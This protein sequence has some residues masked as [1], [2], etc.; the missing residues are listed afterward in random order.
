MIAIEINNVKSFMNKLLKDN[1]FDE[2]EVISIDLRTMI[3][4]FIDGKIDAT[5]LSEEEKEDTPPS[6]YICW[7][8]IKPH[9]FS[10]ISSAKRP[11]YFKIVFALSKKSKTSLIEK[12]MTDTPLDSI[13]GFTMNILYENQSLRIITGTNYKQ[14][15]LDKSLEQYFD[16]SIKK[17]LFKHE[18]EFDSVH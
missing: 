3:Q 10:I 9:I 14:F 16:Q 15:T 5:Y 2:F 8:K 12:S 6:E 7:S 13:N 11:S 17:F 4:Y 18:I 1:P